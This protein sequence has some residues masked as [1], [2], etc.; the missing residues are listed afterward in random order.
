VSPFL[1]HEEIENGEEEQ[2]QV[3]SI[4][5]VLRDGG[6]LLHYVTRKYDPQQPDQER[7]G[8]G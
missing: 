2:A 1:V 5:A 6:S 3:L 7:E 8:L 4:R